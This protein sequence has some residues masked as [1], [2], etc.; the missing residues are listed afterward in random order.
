MITVAVVTYRSA[1][2]LP[3]LLDAL[4]AALAGV[5]DWRLV[6]ADNASDDATVELVRARY[7]RA[8]IVELGANR[9]YAAGVNACVAAEPEAD[10]VLVLN[11][12][13]RPA[14]GCVRELL[15]AARSPVGIAVP[16]LTDPGGRLAFSLRREPTVR[17]ALGEAL[18]GGRRAGRFPALSEV[19]ADPGAYS[20]ASTSDW[21]SGAAM[22][23]T[24]DCLRSV[25][26]WDESFFLY[27]EETDFALRARDAGFAL[28]LVPAAQ[29]VHVG[30]ESHESAR[31]WAL[32]MANRVRLFAR[33]NGRLRAA[34]FRAALAAGEAL[35]SVRGGVGRDTHRAALHVLVRGKV[36]GGRCADFSP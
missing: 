18:L 11:P 4:P 12:D 29:A 6:V 9:G 26:P 20:T 2:V 19:V 32:L 27:S 5:P 21:A 23:L 22:L 24:R 31:L 14:P 8:R 16:R 30:G 35:R 1:D 28:R 25:G 3:G 10:A 33:R 34:G 17:R 13:V 15:A 36:M 7:P